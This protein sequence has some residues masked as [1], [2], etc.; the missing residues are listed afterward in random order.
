MFK[1]PNLFRYATSELSQDAFIAWLLS[2]ANP[3]YASAD[4]Y[5]HVCAKRLIGAFFEKHGR[6]VPDFSS[7]VVTP[8]DE[9]IDVLCVLDEK[10][11]IIIEDKTNTCEHSDQLTRY[12][13]KVKERD[14]EPENVLAIYLKTGDQSHYNDVYRKGFQPFLR[15]D[16]LA[17]LESGAQTPSDIFH[18]YLEWLRHLEARVE[19]YRTKPLQSWG[20]H[21][22]IGFYKALKE[23]LGEGDWGYVPNQSGGFLGFWIY[24]RDIAHVQLANTSENTCELRFRIGVEDAA[25]RRALRREWFAKISHHA[26]EFGLRARK[27]TR[28]GHGRSMVVAVLDREDFRQPD[29]NGLL[30]MDATA[31]LI[32]Q[33]GTLLT[34]LHSEPAT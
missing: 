14:Y 11:A 27:P 32:R 22:W 25:Q 21:A 7:V 13:T 2:W 34:C 31:Q 1:K 30:D 10:F 29:A 9:R 17:V 20:W 8:Q 24:F 5:L 15:R 19:A 16:L 33:A 23:H 12:L 28:F 3:Q 18:C 4:P 26:G 6:A